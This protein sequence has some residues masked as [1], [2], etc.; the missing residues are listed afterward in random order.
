MEPSPSLTAPRKRLR[1]DSH[2]DS[3]E[4]CDG[5][6][7][8]QESGVSPRRRRR[9]LM[10]VPWGL[11][12]ALP[13]ALFEEENI[14]YLP[15]HCSVARKQERQVERAVPL[16]LPGGLRVRRPIPELDGVED[17]AWRLYE[18]NQHCM[19][20]SAPLRPAVDLPNSVRNLE[21]Y[22]QMQEKFM[23]GLPEVFEG[24]RDLT[25][26]RDSRRAML[27]MKAS[28]LEELCKHLK[29]EH[30]SEEVADFI[31]EA[32]M[33]HDFRSR[34]ERLNFLAVEATDYSKKF[35]KLECKREARLRRLQ[36]E[37]LG[38]R[39]LALQEEEF[40]I[41]AARN[42]F[43]TQCAATKEAMIRT[44]RERILR[45]QRFKTSACPLTHSPTSCEL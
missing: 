17:P 30:V 42:D 23:E 31:A 7:E 35:R 44:L 24:S 1:S 9:V 32:R 41:A 21:V 12:P 22:L 2:G 29:V 3:I 11:F 20:S 27:E 4:E 19:S 6:G 38:S 45:L 18:E 8:R 26:L 14:R 40:Q 15:A 39:S 13:G 25:Q 37:M 33:H 5:G 36:K 10:P 28:T 43:K 16:T 34:Q